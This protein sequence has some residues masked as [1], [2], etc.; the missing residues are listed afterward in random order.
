MKNRRIRLIASLTSLVALFTLPAASQ[1]LQIDYTA[2]VG[3]LS[4]DVPAGVALGST[5]T[6]RVEVD[7]QY[8]PPDCSTA[9]WYGC[10]DY[11]TRLPGYLFQFDTG[12]QSVT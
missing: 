10:Y 5:I 7:L 1:R 12:V 8:L 4:G 11:V 2:T 3:H 9:A 6:G